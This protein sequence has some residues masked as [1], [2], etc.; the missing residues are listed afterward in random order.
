MNGTGY[1]PLTRFGWL[2]ASGSSELDAVS[3]FSLPEVDRSWRGLH[4]FHA[5]IVQMLDIER[6]AA[7]EG[8]QQRIRQRSSLDAATVENALRRLT[9]PIQRARDS[10]EDANSCTHPVFVAAQMVATAMGIKLT[11]RSNF[12]RT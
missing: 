10:Q 5:L 12:C 9:A 3:T 11:P 1:Y 7:L 8:E 6:A 4:G 2:Q